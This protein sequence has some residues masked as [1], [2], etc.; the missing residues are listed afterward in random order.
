[1]DKN[2]LKLYNMVEKV[3]EFDYE[4]LILRDT[5]SPDIARFIQ[6]LKELQDEHQRQLLWTLQ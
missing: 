4:D 3:I 5:F 2:H 1:M 6:S